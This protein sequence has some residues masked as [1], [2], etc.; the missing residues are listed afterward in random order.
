MDF[1]ALY[2][3]IYTVALGQNIL[4]AWMHPL[5]WSLPCNSGQHDDFVCFFS[6][7]PAKALALFILD[8]CTSVLVSLLDVVLPKETTT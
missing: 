3:S 2:V 4:F 7:I 5:F 8:G 1:L 6:F